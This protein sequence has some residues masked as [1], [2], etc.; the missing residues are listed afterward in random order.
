M[1]SPASRSCSVRKPQGSVSVG[2]ASLPAGPASYS[3][4]FGWSDH[5]IQRILGPARHEDRDHRPPKHLRVRL[6]SSYSGMGCLRSRLI[7]CVAPAQHNVHVD[8]VQHSQTEISQAC[9]SA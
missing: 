1:T 3:E 2:E 7:V 6:T 9:A 8:V 5:I 4:V